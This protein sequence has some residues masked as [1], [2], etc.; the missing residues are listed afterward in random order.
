VTDEPA[1]LRE[2]IGDASLVF[3]CA[4]MVDDWASAR[5][6][7]PRECGGTRNLLEA[8]RGLPG[9]RRFVM[10]GSMVVLGMGPQIHFD[11]TAPMVTRATITTTQ[12]I[13]S[14]ELAMNTPGSTAYRWSSASRRIFTDRGSA[15]LSG[16]FEALKSGR[17]KYIGDGNQPLTLVYVANLVQA[18]LLAAPRTA[19]RGTCF[20]SPTASR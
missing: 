4:A 7:G 2:L 3:H 5:G 19:S 18:L 16:L 13:L 10:V 8:C 20:S 6:H 12:K 11:E 14:T 15:V 1:R 17:F 9:L